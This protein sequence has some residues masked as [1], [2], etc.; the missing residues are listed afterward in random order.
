MSR[1]TRTNQR[2]DCT[3]RFVSVQC[4]STPRWKDFFTRQTD[5]SR[6]IYQRSCM[7]ELVA[8]CDRHILH[9]LAHVSWVGS[10]LICRS[11]TTSHNGRWETK[12]SRWRDV[13]EV[14]TVSYEVC[15]ITCVAFLFGASVVHRY[16]QV[17]TIGG[18]WCF[19]YPEQKKRK[20]STCRLVRDNVSKQTKS[21]E[22]STCRRA[23][24][25]HAE[26]SKWA[27]K[28][29]SAG[30]T[31]IYNYSQNAGVMLEGFAVSF[32]L[33]QIQH[34]LHFLSVLLWMQFVQ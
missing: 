10:A 28:S 9:D 20:T 11:C 16:L 3:N 13:S 22:A 5:L 14:W 6:C 31:K 1:N 29:K 21:S 30:P 4:S 19:F 18:N 24:S 34:W 2:G 32:D 7:T 23:C 17:D 33:N 8:G 15:I 25:Q 26:F 12:W 27:K